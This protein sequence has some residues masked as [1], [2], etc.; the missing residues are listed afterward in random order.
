MLADP[1]NLMLIF[2]GVTMN[3]LLHVFVILSDT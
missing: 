1:Y 3:N 2:K